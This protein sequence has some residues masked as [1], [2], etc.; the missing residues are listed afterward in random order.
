M[1]ASGRARGFEGASVGLAVCASVDACHAIVRADVKRRQVTQGMSVDHTTFQRYRA[2]WAQ[3]QRAAH[4]ASTRAPAPTCCCGRRCTP[5]Q[6]AG[7]CA[8]Q[9]GR[10][11]MGAGQGGAPPQPTQFGECSWDGGAVSQCRRPSSSRTRRQCPVCLPAADR[12]GHSC[13][14]RGK[15]AC[16]HKSDKGGSRVAS[17]PRAET[18]TRAPLP[19]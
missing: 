9:G 18:A 1:V 2:E 3:A 17:H 16:G 13:R 11:G 5:R 10:R 7:A 12:P 15:R 8:G 19:R 4:R 14:G 6:S